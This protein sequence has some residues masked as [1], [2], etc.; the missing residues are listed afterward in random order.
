MRVRHERLDV[1]AYP[2]APHVAAFCK[3]S[4]AARYQRLGFGEHDASSFPRG[5]GEARHKRGL[6]SGP[7]PGPESW[8]GA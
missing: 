8:S 5:G 3:L 4:R 7:I 2:L 1:L 6:E